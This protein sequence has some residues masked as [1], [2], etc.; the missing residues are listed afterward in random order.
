[1]VQGADITKDAEFSVGG[2]AV[3]SGGLV[4]VE[5]GANQCRVGG[6]G[7]LSVEILVA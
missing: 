5:T 3:D 7:G 4:G 1:M 6:F 2:W